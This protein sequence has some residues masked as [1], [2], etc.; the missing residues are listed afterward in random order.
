MPINFDII[1]NV[2]V[3]GYYG[4]VYERLSKEGRHFDMW[5]RKRKTLQ[6]RTSL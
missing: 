6:K 1:L 4:R 2:P 5:G 3:N